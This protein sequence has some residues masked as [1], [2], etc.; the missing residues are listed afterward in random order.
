MLLIIHLVEMDFRQF[1][2][3]MN[4]EVWTHF[5]VIEAFTCFKNLFRRPQSP[6]ECFHVDIKTTYTF[7]YFNIIVNK[8][9]FLISYL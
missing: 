5:K 1:I 4:Y 8:V 3:V 7:N 2:C 9:F 6:D